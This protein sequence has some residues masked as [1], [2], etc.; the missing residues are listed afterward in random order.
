MSK[1]M[2]TRVCAGVYNSKQ[3]NY[4][5]I[6]GASEPGTWELR[7]FGSFVDSF[8][9]LADAKKAARFY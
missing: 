5:I 7:Q 9:S 1:S 8:S 6:L 4:E 3:Q 2:W